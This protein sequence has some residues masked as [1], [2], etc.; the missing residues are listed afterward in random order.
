MLLVKLREGT[1]IKKNRCGTL[2]GDAMLFQVQP[3]LDGIPLKLILEHLLHLGIIRRKTP[4]AKRLWGTLTIE[5]AG[6]LSLVFAL[7][8]TATILSE[9]RELV[10]TASA[11]LRGQKASARSAGRRADGFLI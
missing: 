5:Y 1:S 6:R 4:P 10:K 3:S 2:K 7:P 8:T 11:L 9:F